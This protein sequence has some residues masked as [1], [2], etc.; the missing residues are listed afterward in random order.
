[1]V[2]VEAARLRL[3]GRVHETPLLSSATIDALAGT[4]VLFK[5]EHLQK[6]GSFKARGAT[7][8]VRRIQEEG[9]AQ[10]VV[11]PLPPPQTN[12]ITHSSGNHGLGLAY[13]AR[14]AGLPATV[15]CP[16]TAPATKRDA[17]AAYGAQVHL[18]E[19]TMKSR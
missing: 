8:A 13:A 1:M 2:D 10:G 3:K 18:C 6:T 15:V 17:I 7:N 16:R 11:S 19:P 14:D 9:S 5:C 4:H 12:Q